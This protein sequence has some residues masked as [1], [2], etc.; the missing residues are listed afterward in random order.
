MLVKIYEKK[1]LDALSGTVT[2]CFHFI[3]AFGNKL[4]L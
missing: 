3:Q 2:N 1:E 4:K